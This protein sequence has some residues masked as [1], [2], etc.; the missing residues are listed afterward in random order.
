M[1]FSKV[2]IIGRSNVGKSTL[3]NILTESDQALVSQYPGTTR[4]RNIAVCSWGGV[5]FE[6]IDTGGLEPSLLSKTNKPK[7]SQ[8]TPPLTAEIQ[9]DVMK[10]TRIAI[11]NA[12]L[13]LLIIDATVG[14]LPEERA[15]LQYLLKQEK[16]FF[17]VLNKVDNPKIRKRAGVLKFPTGT[18]VFLV[19][20]MNGVGCGDLLDAIVNR[21]PKVAAT[22]LSETEIRVALVGKPNVGKSSLLNRIC[23]EE[24]VIVSPIPFTTRETHDI[25]ISHKGHSIRFIDTVGLRK[26]MKHGDT[27]KKKGWEKTIRSIHKADVVI[28]LL[29][30]LS[31]IDTQDRRILA[32]I[33]KTDASLLLGINKWDLV[34]EKNSDTMRKLQDKIFRLL[35]FIK[36][37]PLVFISAKTGARIQNLLDMVLQ[38]YS[39][40]SVRLQDKELQQFLIDAK[41]HHRPPQRKGLPRPQIFE[42]KQRDTSPPRFILFVNNKGSFHPSYMRYLT[43]QL[44]ETFRLLGC[45]VKI[46]FRSI[47]HK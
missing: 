14:M 13:L 33:V 41:R 39:Y 1:I 35:P 37:A 47:L 28:F 42:M 32:E 23:G 36:H 43:N 40:R 16:A 10:Q 20:A 45:P 22:H 7:R 12:H 26:K 46:E 2:A 21:I 4:D 25:M 3:F 44:Y 27:L 8:H 6:L 24:R 15:I 38:V 31:N 18:D 29:E 34:P 11:T 17:L 30:A 9:Q 5:D 19:S